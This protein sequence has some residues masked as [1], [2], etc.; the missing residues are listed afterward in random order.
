MKINDNFIFRNIQIRIWEYGISQDGKGFLFLLQIMKKSYKKKALLI[1]LHE[2]TK[3]FCIQRAINKS[4]GT[5][6]GRKTQ[7]Y[8]TNG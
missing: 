4:W 3:F 5:D 2:N 7:V 1:W 6:K 8:G